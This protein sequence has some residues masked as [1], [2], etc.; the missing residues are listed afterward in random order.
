MNITKEFIK[1]TKG[2]LSVAI[3]NPETKTKKLAILCP[4]FLDSK[5]YA[6]LTELANRLTEHG[7]TSVRFDPTG[8]WESGGNITDYTISC[9]YKKRT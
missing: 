1:G 6:G 5:D 9:R 3:H 4:G 8:V 2:D 7:Y